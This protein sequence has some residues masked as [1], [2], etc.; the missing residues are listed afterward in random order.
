MRIDRW[1]SQNIEVL[2]PKWTKRSKSCNNESLREAVADEYNKQK[3]I[4]MFVSEAEKMIRSKSLRA[5]KKQ[6]ELSHEIQ[7]G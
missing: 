4:A 2:D 3:S 6:I 1:V 7:E 5:R